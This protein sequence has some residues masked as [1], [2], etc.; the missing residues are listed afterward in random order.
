MLVTLGI[1]IWKTLRTGRTKQK[2]RIFRM[3][4]ARWRRSFKTPLAALA[5]LSTTPD[6]LFAEEL[7]AYAAEAELNLDDLDVNAI[8]SLSDFEDDD[9]VVMH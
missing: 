9:D 2:V 6:D 5:P 1:L 4:P 7:E 3:R 8:F